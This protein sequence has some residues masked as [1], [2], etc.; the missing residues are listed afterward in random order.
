[1]SLGVGSRLGHYE[2]TALIGEGGMGQVYQATDTNLDRQVALKILPEAFATDPDR[3]ARFQREAQVL[4]SLNHPNIAA[5]HGLEDSEGTKALVLELVEGPT[6]ADRIA[7]APIPV[8][9]ALPIAKQI[10]EALEA[11][12][13]SGVI[14]RDLKP[15]NIK[16]QDDGTVKVLDFGLAKALAAESS[17]ADLSEAPTVTATVGGTREGVI[18][19]TAAYMSP[20]QARGKPLDKR[21]DIWS[22]GC[23]LFEMLSGRAVFAQPTLSETLAKVLET[24]PDLTALSALTPPLVRRLITRCLEK[25]PSERLQHIGDARIDIRD[26]LAEPA[27]E[28]AGTTAGSGAPSTGSKLARVASIGF[29]VFLAALAGWFAATRSNT[30]TSPQVI[31]LDVT[32]AAPL[33]ANPLR[34]FIAVSP[35]GAH[36]AYLTT[37]SLVIRSLERS[38]TISVG[39]GVGHS[40]FFSPDS[41]SVAFFTGVSPSLERVPVGGGTPTVITSF[42]VRPLGGSWG[43]DDTIVFANNVGLFRVS[44]EGGEPELLVRPD[45]GQGELFYAWSEILPGGGAALFTVVRDAPAAG[46]DIAAVD[47]ETLE[48]RTLLRGGSG[49]RYATTGHLVYADGERLQAVPFDLD[50]M[51]VAGDPVTVVAG[52]VRL[53]RDGGAEFGLST[54]GTLVYVPAPSLGQRSLVW[55]DRDGR[56]EAVG[57]PLLPYVYP[58]ISPDGT[59]VAVDLRDS[60]DNRDIYIWDFVRQNMTR[61]TDHPTEDLFAVWSRDS[62]RVFFS[63]N[64]NDVFNVFFRAADGAAP[65]A[66]FLESPRVQMVNSLTPDGT[67][68]MIA[69]QAQPGN[70]DIVGLA[71]G[72]SQEIEQLLTTE[73]SE[74]SGEVSPDGNWLAYQS[75]DTG[76]REV[77]V[78]PFPEATGGASRFRLRVAGRLCGDTMAPSCFSEV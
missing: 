42:P 4:A 34:R 22:F 45:P 70:F 28:I 11:A 75:D 62:Q 8:D 57:A 14:H 1:M 13:E 68:L 37:A 49:A 50:E 23:V 46:F 47:L 35:D 51:N 19:G 73:Y 76:Q 71:V 53:A 30:N 12:H 54:T 33:P 31:R 40:P 27:L 58:R 78:R 15:A 56:E 36:I 29:V 25:N 48:Y 6:L 5:I 67:R 69:E 66:L 32:P 10:V 41:Q 64:Q 59:R 2:V 24:T 38:D 72:D 9:E 20:E 39:S 60:V 17:A 43:D 7:Q 16:V 65:A 3:L 26:A 52:P 44:A 18:L 74:T 63:S 61:L 55:V 21:T 77:W